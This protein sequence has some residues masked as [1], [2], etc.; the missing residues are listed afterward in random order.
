MSNLPKQHS[1]EI[2]LS[3]IMKSFSEGVKSFVR[4]MFGFL[5]FLRK[6]LLANLNSLRVGKQ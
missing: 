5:Q 1:D 3:V 6:H 2:E 4:L